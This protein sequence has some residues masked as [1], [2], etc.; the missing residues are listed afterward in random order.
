MVFGIFIYLALF[1]GG[2]LQLYNLTDRGFS[3]RILIDIL[4][5]KNGNLTQEE[6]MKNYGGGKGIDWMYQKRIDGMLDNNFVVVNDDIVRITPKGKKTA[7]VFSFLRKFL[8]L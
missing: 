6:I 2:I 4:E 7:V 1:G 5:S 8:N 3:L